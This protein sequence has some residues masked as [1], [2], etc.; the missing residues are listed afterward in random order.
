VDEGPTV[1]NQGRLDAGDGV[2]ILSDDNGEGRDPTI[3][4][5]GDEPVRGV[6]IEKTV[7]DPSGPPAL[8]G[9]ALTWRITV[10]NTGTV[11][12]GDLVI[13][14]DLPAGLVFQE[15]TALPPGAELEVSPA[16]AGDGNG[17]VRISQVGVVAGESVT[18]VLVMAVDPTLA[19]NTQI[20]NEAQVEGPGVA[21]V[22]AKLACVDAEIRFGGVVGR[23]F[24]DLDGDAGFSDGDVGFADMKVTLHPMADPD[25]PATFEALS[26]EGG[27]FALLNLPV[28]AY[29][30]RVFSATNVLMATQ[31]DVQVVEE[32]EL[33]LIIDPSGRVYESQEGT[34]VDGAQVFI[35]R[36]ED[37]NNDPYDEASRRLRTLVPLEDLEA[38]SMQGQRTA[39]GGVYRFAVRRAGRY[40]MEVVPPGLSQISPS[41]LVPPVPGYAFTD[42][43]D[44][45]VVPDAVPVVAPGADRTYFLAFELNGFEDEFFH[46]HVPIDALSSLIDLQKRSR[47]VEVTRGQVVTYEIDIINRSPRDLITGSETGPAVLQ[48]VL[49]KGFKYVAGSGTWTRVQ[50]G[51]EIPLAT[52]DP[53]EARILRFPVE[54]N[55][56]EALRLR[57]Q[58]ALGANVKARAVYTNRAQLLLAGGNVPISRVATADVRV[59]PD[60]D[61]DQGALIGK[62]F[63]DTNTDGLQ[64]EGEVGLAGVR[65]Y[66]D[67]GWYAETDSGGLF[68][69]QD[70]DP[71]SHAVKVDAGTLLPGAIFTTDALR[72]I[73]FT[74]GLPAKVSFGVTCPT[75]EVSGA[76]IEV[77]GEGVAG[78]LAALRDQL[79]VVSGDAKKLTA[80]VR[81][82][83]RKACESTGEVAGR[84]GRRRDPRSAGGGRWGGGQPGLRHPRLQ[85]GTA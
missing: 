47:R 56:G 44:R 70:L 5:V 55:A 7:E 65:L 42:D 57:Y 83:Q 68:H 38:E 30:V 8:A 67:T 18:I 54:I 76:R 41:L 33:S 60:A 53:A 10:A 39:H 74:P 71:G 13:T 79:A 58:A 26:A 12:L 4:P 25:G 27:T 1:Q 43:P 84:W 15:A 34:L 19:A 75:E 36:D 72:V 82:V 77:A 21:A 78:A 73:H 2:V 59:V 52:F 49:P 11:D 28:G 80:R 62:V 31:D 32:T 3:V 51:K 45:N 63:C 37:T 6:T 23:V 61:F 66:L 81:G 46:N 22:V 20:C 17:Q 29:R 16:P 40:L 64:S 85:G 14:D 24:E 48:D 50:S 9:E 69:F 35:Y